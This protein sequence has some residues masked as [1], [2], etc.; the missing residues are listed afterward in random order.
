MLAEFHLFGTLHLAI[1]GATILAAVALAFVTRR[2]PRSALATRIA[3]AS[4]LVID[5]LSWHFYRYFAQGVRFPEILPLEM[6]D[7]AFWL[8]V[9]ALFTLEEHV[10]ELAYYWGIAGSGMA[11]LTPYLRAPLHTYQSCQYFAGHCLLIVSVLY[12]VWSRQARPRPRSWWFALWCLNVY[13]AVAGL[14]DWLGG[15]NFMY[16]R[17][18]PAALSL[19]NIFGRWPWYVVASEFVALTMFLLLQLPL[20]E[21]SR[22]ELRASNQKPTM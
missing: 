2:R 22:Y 10:F 13:A 6:C 17:E 12:L 14:V 3:L 20:R 7:V 15:T 8:V 19:L 18:K 1:L 5:G 4:I 16:L 11:V 9:V 21:A